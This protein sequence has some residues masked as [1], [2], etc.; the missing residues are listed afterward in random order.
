MVII[1]FS[2]LI[3]L[4]SIWNDFFFFCSIDVLYTRPLLQLSP[5]LFDLKRKFRAFTIK[6]DRLLSIITVW[7]P[8]SFF[9]FFLSC[10][11]IG[12]HVLLFFF[13]TFLGARESVCVE[14]R[15]PPLLFCIF[16]WLWLPLNN[17]NTCTPCCV[18][19][20]CWAFSLLLQYELL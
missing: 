19:R 7:I 9:F 6:L 8:F 20:C 18:T 11:F 13:S 2:V 17:N 15:K 3:F 12:K 4:Q 14:N 10:F 1:L 5:K 16:L